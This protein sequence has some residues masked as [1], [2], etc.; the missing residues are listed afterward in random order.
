MPDGFAIT[1]E[2][3]EVL[4]AVAGNPDAS[5]T[6]GWQFDE[7][8]DCHVFTELRHASVW[9]DLVNRLAGAMYDGDKP[10]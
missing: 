7:A 3:A 5:E 8:E 9:R 6:V 10:S 1:R 4:L 2:E